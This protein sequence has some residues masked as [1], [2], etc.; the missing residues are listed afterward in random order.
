[1]RRRALR[2]AAAALARKLGAA[3]VVPLA[4]CAYKT[5]QLLR[6]NAG[7]TVPAADEAE[8]LTEE[9]LEDVLLPQSERVI[10]IYDEDTVESMQRASDDPM[11]MA[12][13]MRE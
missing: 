10:E 5:I 6:S 4:I 12:E 1:M 9:P 7:F 2:T 11:A 8:E 13:L 3:W